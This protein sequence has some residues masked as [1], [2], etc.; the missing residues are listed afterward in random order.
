MITTDIVIVSYKDE[1]ELKRCIDSI[2][3]HC[4]DY[5]LIIEDNNTVN[6]FF[7]RAVNEG[8]SKGTAPWVWLVNSDAIILPGAQEGLINHFSYGP[9]VG[10][11]G[12]MQLDYDDQDMIRHS[13]TIRAFPSGQHSGGRLSMGH[14]NIPTKQKWLN[15]ASV[16]LRRDMIS[17]IGLLDQSMVLLYSDSSYC[18]YARSQGYECW[19]TPASRVLHKLNA[20]KKVTEWHEKD[21][22]SFM[23]RWGITYNQESNSFSY[24]QEFQKLDM[25]P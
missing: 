12:S 17:K 11:V 7:T 22:K 18:Y 13:G 2:K 24:S 9:Q 15:F 21:M 14:G 5:N 23:L 25:F 4:K 20:S 10:I 16:M 6:R 3:E 19:Y 8:I 1:V